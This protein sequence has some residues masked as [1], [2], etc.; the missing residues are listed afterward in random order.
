MTWPVDPQRYLLCLGVTGLFAVTPGPAVLFCIAT[1]VE[2]GRGGVV[3]AVAGIDAASLA[4]FAAAGLGIGALMA[5]A[6]QLFQAL[7][8]AGVL[9]LV[10]LGV[11]SA[12]AGLATT[13][14]PA[15]P[16]LVEPGRRSAGALAQGFAVQILNPK[17]L[18]YFSTVLPPFLDARRPIPA[19]I[20]LF[21]AG[22]VGLDTLAL[23]A[24]GLTGAALAK[25]LQAVRAARR[26][27]LVRGLLLIA[28]AALVAFERTRG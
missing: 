9:Y 6:P 28:A 1:G 13:L 14:S 8:W 25:R 27:A 3:R 2:R 26:F 4:W 20:A 21:A 18:L 17:V 12:Q 5:Q 22:L 15:L 16:P 19:Q 10:W 23:G 11:R 24:Y 7:A